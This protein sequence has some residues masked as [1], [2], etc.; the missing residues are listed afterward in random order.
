[1]AQDQANALLDTCRSKLSADNDYDKMDPLQIVDAMTECMEVEVNASIAKQQ[2]EV[3]FQSQVRASMAQKLVPY[4]CGDV[5]FTTSIEVVNRTWHFED[6]PGD[7]YYTYDMQVFHERPSNRIFQVPH[8]V[9]SDEC[10]ALTYFVSPDTKYIRFDAVHD[11]TKQGL[12]VRRLANRISELTRA[13]LGWTDLDLQLQHTMYGQELFDILFDEQGVSVLPPCQKEFLETL[14]NDEVPS[15]CRLPGAKPSKVETRKFTVQD[16][17]QVAD[18]FLF[19][20][21]STERPQLGGIHFPNAAVHINPQPHLMVMAIHR[22]LAVPDLEDYTTEYHFCPNYEILKHT[23][24]QQD[25]NP[26]ISKEGKTS[27]TR[28]KDATDEL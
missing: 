5:N 3:A 23:F 6:S 14:E 20:N 18:V 13:I 21:D 9:T 10:E 28:T 1:M 26:T 27:S 19:C 8:F 24:F 25:S 4:A 17:S 11:K 22:N 16:S 12:L 2:E 15:T 7:G